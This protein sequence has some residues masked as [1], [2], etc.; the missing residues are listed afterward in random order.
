MTAA[1]AAVQVRAA[2]PWAMFVLPG[3]QQAVFN[4]SHSTDLLQGEY[5]IPT[6]VSA[7][8][9]CH[10]VMHKAKVLRTLRFSVG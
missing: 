7:R 5:G 2:W 1:P 4:H 10:Y 6:T 9:Q 3:H 8:R